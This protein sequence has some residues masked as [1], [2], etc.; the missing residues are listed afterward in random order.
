MDHKLNGKED[1]G[2]VGLGEFK[3]KV[4]IS[5]SSSDANGAATSG[6]SNALSVTPLVTMTSIA[7]GSVLMGTMFETVG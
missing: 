1:V 4:G 3:M 5:G 2:D 6:A 7:F